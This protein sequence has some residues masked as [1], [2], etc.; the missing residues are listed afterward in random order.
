[1]SCR[2]NTRPHEQSCARRFFFAPPDAPE[3]HGDVPGA[4]PGWRAGGGTATET[5]R[6]TY[7]GARARLGAGPPSG[8]VIMHIFRSIGRAGGRGLRTGVEGLIAGLD[9]LTRRV[10]RASDRVEAHLARRTTRLRARRRPDG[11]RPLD[12][13]FLHL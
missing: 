4:V 6:S 11:P 2:Q 3:R 7:P 5:G 13:P 9:G 10:G 12:L 8:K 1:M